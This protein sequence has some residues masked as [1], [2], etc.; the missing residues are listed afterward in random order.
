MIIMLRVLFHFSYEVLPLFI[1]HLLEKALKELNALINVHLIVQLAEVSIALGGLPAFI[2]LA[3]VHPHHMRFI[4]SEV[5]CFTWVDLR[6]HCLMKILVRYLPIFVVVKLVEYAVE[7]LISQVK[8]PVLEVEPQFC[9]FNEP[10][11]LLV[12]INK[13]LPNS[14]PLH[15]DLF[16]DSFLKSFIH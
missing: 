13:G 2:V 10:R 9:G 11:F 4:L 7:L 15:L 1:P 8:S 3:L 5:K 14:L 6:A 16:N 12:K